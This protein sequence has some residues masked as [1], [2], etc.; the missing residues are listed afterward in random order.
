MQGK[1][2]GKT[3]KGSKSTAAELD[4]VMINHL[5]DAALSATA[6]L[7]KVLRSEKNQGADPLQRVYEIRDLATKPTSTLLPPTPSEP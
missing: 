3:T 4:P 1:A 5:S 2:A 7:S 6:K